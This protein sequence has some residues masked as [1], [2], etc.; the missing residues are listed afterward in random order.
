MATKSDLMQLTKDQLVSLIVARGNTIDS[1]NQADHLLFKLFEH[2]ALNA[3]H[4][5]G[6]FDEFHETILGL[7]VVEEKILAGLAPDALTN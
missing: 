2:D 5:L 1:L 7:A 3:E 4:L 6:Y